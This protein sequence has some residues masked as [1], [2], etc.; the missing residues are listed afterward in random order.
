MGSNHFASFERTCQVYNSQVMRSLFI[1]HPEV[2]SCFNTPGCQYG[3]KSGSDNKKNRDNMP[4]CITAV[5]WPCRPRRDQPL[6]EKFPRILWDTKTS[7]G[8]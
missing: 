3:I 1:I 6:V 8:E 2:P 4:Q 5:V 7:V